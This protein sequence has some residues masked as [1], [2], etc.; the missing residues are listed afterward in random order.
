MPSHRPISVPQ[1]DFLS[2][3]VLRHRR[4]HLDLVPDQA[5]DLIVVCGGWERCDRAYR[6]NRPSFPWL[7]IEILAAGRLTLDLGDRR[8]QLG[9]GA[10][11]AYGPGIAQRIVPDPS[12]LPVKYY[13][14]CAGRQ[15]GPL[16]AAAGLAPGAVVQ[17]GALDEVVRLADVLI[18]AGSRGD[19]TSS[20]MLLRCLLTAIQASA[21]PGALPASG[22]EATYRQC[23]RILSDA[24]G[25]FVSVAAA[26]R[27]TG[28]SAEHL[29][30]LFR[31][32]AGVTASA[33]LRDLR[34]RQAPDLLRLPGATVAGVAEQLGFANPF[35]FSRAFRRRFGLA[36]AHL[37]ATF[38][39]T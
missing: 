24:D 13:V 11:F 27:A 35:H 8:H 10:C 33:F 38:S 12:A 21:R 32:Y 9:P 19:G 20:T 22:A 25:G 15:A 29:C 1:P 26:A 36:P 37:R 28:I 16:L 39:R 4:F 30:R 23:R 5:A 14:D 6:I 31:R 34:L 3:Q 2:K 18:D 17:V 7:A